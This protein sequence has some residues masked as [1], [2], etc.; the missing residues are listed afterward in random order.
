MIANKS[1]EHL[2]IIAYHRSPYPR[3]KFD[4]YGTHSLPAR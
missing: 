2:H 3:L 4:A 1:L